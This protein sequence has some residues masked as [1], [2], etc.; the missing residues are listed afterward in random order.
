MAYT[1]DKIVDPFRG[2]PGFN[3]GLILEAYKQ[4]YELIKDKIMWGACKD[5][6]NYIIHVRMP[7]TDPYCSDVF[8]DVVFEFFPES[9]KLIDSRSINDYSVLVFSNCPSFTFTFTYA[10]NKYGLLVPWLTDKCIPDCLNRPA[11]HR[12][13]GSQIG[14]DMK[15]WFAAYHL[16]RIGILNY[17][18]RFD[19]MVNTSKSSIQKAVLSQGAMLLRRMRI[20]DINKKKAQASKAASKANQRETNRFNDYRAKKELEHSIQKTYHNKVNSSAVSSRVA[21]KART[22]RKPK[23]H[24]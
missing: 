22:S 15:T 21:K 19:D 17:K 24:R 16:Q 18:L 11:V 5:G 14:S 10:Y 2:M 4:K 9:E 12:N 13:R 7:S 23:S 20:A 6:N 8:Y 1:L 3:K